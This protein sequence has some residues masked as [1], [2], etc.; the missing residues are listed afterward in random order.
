MPI[1]FT[2]AFKI[3]K[4]TFDAT[5][6]FDPILDVDSKLFIDPALLEKTQC[7]EFLY[8]RN[9][10]EHYFSGII[11]LLKHSQVKGDRFWKRADKELCFTEIRGT[12]LGY[13][14]KSIDG[15][16]IGPNL[17]TRF[18]DQSNNLL[19]QAQMIQF[20]LSCLERLKK[21][22][23]AIESATSLLSGL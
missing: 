1:S 13:S 16:G 7:K 11:A 5:G 18:L 23:V 3:D 15:N 9:E 19:F 20:F 17:R 8:A 2:D 4:D 14:E 6:A 12:C 21:R 22:L 10:M